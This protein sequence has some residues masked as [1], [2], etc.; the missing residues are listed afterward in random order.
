MWFQIEAFR[1][2]PKEFVELLISNLQRDIYLDG[3]V[4]FH[5]DDDA[6]AMYFL[7]YGTVAIYIGNGKDEVNFSLDTSILCIRK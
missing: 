4:I 7:K 5:E 3:D 6:E 2:C 1:D